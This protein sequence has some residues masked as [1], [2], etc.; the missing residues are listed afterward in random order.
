MWFISLEA[1]L[2]LKENPAETFRYIFRKADQRKSEL[3]ALKNVSKRFIALE[4][5]RIRA[6]IIKSIKS[7]ESYSYGKFY[8]KPAELRKAYSDEFTKIS[9]KSLD[10]L[11]KDFVNPEFLPIEVYRDLFSFFDLNSANRKVALKIK[12]WDNALRLAQRKIK[13]LNDKSV[14][15]ALQK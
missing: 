11:L 10:S 13:P 7:V 8:Q 6:D 12:D 5:A 2:N 14:I 9:G 4:N 1:G 15:P 3:V